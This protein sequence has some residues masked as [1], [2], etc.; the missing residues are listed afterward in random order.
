VAAVLL[1]ALLLTPATAQMKLG[2]IIA[3]A[4]F[5]WTIGK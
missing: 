3:D 4:G 5:D 1:I 2:D